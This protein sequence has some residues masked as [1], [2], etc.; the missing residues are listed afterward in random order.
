MNDPE[1]T[2]LTEQI[3]GLTGINLANYECGRMRRRLEAYISGLSHS[4][5]YSFC[6]LL[7]KDADVLN[8]LTDF[9]TFNHSDFFRDYWAFEELRARILPMIC[10]R[11]TNTLIWS[12]GC[13]NGAEPYTL[14]IILD[15]LQ[16]KPSYTLSATDINTRSLQIAKAGGP[17]SR[18]DI[19]NIPKHLQNK[20]L[21]EEQ[22]S[23][24]VI[25]D[26]RRNILF[27]KYDLIQDNIS[28]GFDLILCRN[29]INHLNDEIRN[30]LNR[31]LFDALTPNG[32]LF[33]GST[34]FITDFASIG[35]TKIG[36]C[37]YQKI[38]TR[39]TP[40]AIRLNELE[41]SIV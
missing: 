11:R 26:L 25:N 39:T 31:R 18:T 4:N 35:F 33:V 23:L 2:Y 40:E 9:I 7:E 14:A 10:Q 38:P 15:S 3:K 34:E 24:Y 17:Y 8:G 20:Y 12:A 32:I 13:A 16:G 28:S 27:N 19:A 5:V 22:K 6:H 36:S 29:I 30:R 21:R 37:F 1:Y 41:N